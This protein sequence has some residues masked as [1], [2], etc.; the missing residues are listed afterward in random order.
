MRT[1]DTDATILN[2]RR[3]D[4]VRWYRFAENGEGEI[5]CMDSFS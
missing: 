4:L 1:A 3:K 5:R 2:V